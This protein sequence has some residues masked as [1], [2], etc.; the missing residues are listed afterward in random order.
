MTIDPNPL[1]VTM[2][3]T[4]LER[5]ALELHRNRQFV[6]EAKP[7]RLQNTL[8]FVNGWATK[9]TAFLFAPRPT[10]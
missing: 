8:R 7:R 9:V 10:H 3:L 4:E 2:H 6:D 5:Q 1:S